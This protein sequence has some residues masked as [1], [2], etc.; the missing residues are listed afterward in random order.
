[1]LINPQLAT[2]PLALTVLD[3]FSSG[4][5]VIGSADA[6]IL[7][8]PAGTRGNHIFSNAETRAW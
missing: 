8:P 1:V 3:I 6:A 5:G 2:A 7:G 4:R